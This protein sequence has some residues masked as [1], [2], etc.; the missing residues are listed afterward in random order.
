MLLLLLLFCCFDSSRYRAR[1]RELNC[2]SVNFPF[3]MA[4]SARECVLTQD[5]VEVEE[6]DSPYPCLYNVGHEV[7]IKGNLLANS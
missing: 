6:A 3:P 5:E 2:F 7:T 4:E 1:E